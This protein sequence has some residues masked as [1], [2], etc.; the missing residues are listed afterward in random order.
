MFLY[1]L[2]MLSVWSRGD[3]AV[4]SINVGLNPTKVRLSFSIRQHALEKP[5]LFLESGIFAD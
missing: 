3:G 2:L 5:D 4:V 1:V